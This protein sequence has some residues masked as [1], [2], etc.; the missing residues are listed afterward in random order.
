MRQRFDRST[1]RETNTK[2]L[3]RLSFDKFV[4]AADGSQLKEFNSLVLR[5]EKLASVATH[6]Q[7]TDRE[8]I[9]V[10]VNEIERTSWFIAATDGAESM[11]Y[12]TGTV[13]KV[14]HE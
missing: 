10:F 4:K 6:E 9:T 14:N 5:I 3:L 8:K 2:A 7:R 13:E 1:K 12:F 11:Q